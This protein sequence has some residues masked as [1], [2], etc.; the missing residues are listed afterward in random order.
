MGQR[1][2]CRV[3]C[4]GGGEAR[5]LPLGHGVRRTSPAKRLES[6]SLRVARA[7]MGVFLATA[8]AVTAQ[9]APSS[10]AVGSAAADE[11]P[12]PKAVFIV[13]PTNGMTDSNLVD[14]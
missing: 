6:R 1:H 13:G 7:T 3:R 8:F 11:G 2:R 14:A 10:P 9:L 5:E 4:S 12:R